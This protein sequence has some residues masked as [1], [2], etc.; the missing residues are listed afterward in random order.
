M[1]DSYTLGSHTFRSRLII[2]TGKYGSLEQ[3]LACTRASGAELV[4]VALRRVDLN[5]PKGQGL[6]DFLPEDVTVLPNTAGCFTARDAV[7]TAELARES[8]ETDLVKLEGI[9]DEEAH[10]VLVN[11]HFVSSEDRSQRIIASGD[12]VSIWPPVA[13]G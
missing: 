6:L 5:A 2:G 13:G 9:A 1:S 4:T 12:V 7:L 8:L 11:G 10:I 3:Q